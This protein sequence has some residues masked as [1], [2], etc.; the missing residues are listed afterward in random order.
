MKKAFLFISIILFAFSSCKQNQDDFISRIVKEST[1]YTS[2]SYKLTEKYYYSSTPDTTITPFEVWIV[3]DKNDLLRKGY[4][5]V[6]NKY[7]PYNMIY[8]AGTFYLAIPPK[9]TTVVYSDFTE[10]FISTI[11]W[12]DVFLKPETLAAQVNDPNIKTLISD[13]LYNGNKCTKLFFSF[14]NDKNG[15]SKTITYL[16]DNNK[17][18]PLYAVLKTKNP[19]QVYTNELFFTDYEFDNVSLE[20]LKERQEQVMSENPI[21]REGSDSEVS[22]LEAMLHQSVAAPLFFGKFYS[23]GENFELAEYIG[24]NVIIVDFWYTH[25]PPC[26]KAMPSLNALYNEYKDKGLKIFGL[27]S[28][29]NQPHSLV[30]LNK[31]L[32]NREIDYDIIMTQ[33]AVDIAYKIKGYPSIY[34]VDKEGKIAFIEI[35]FEEGK[36]EKIKEKVEELLR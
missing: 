21:E 16:I 24:N 5:W 23:D 9:K 19:N 2:I 11:D 1:D 20:E 31:F 34:I 36:F 22:K 30:N 32:G 13:T 8:D 33:P 35:G 7:R 17:L 25:C 27:N 6:N 12:I 29:D 15:E 28:V 18:V 26:V 3:R 4:V 14:S 10:E